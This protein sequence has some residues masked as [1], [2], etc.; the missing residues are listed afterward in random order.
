VVT[1]RSLTW[2]GA[3]LLLLALS[4]RVGADR[5]RLLNGAEVFDELSVSPAAFA[6]I[7]EHLPS[8][9]DYQNLVLYHP[10]FGYYTTGQVN[11]VDDFRTFPTLLAPYFGHMIAEQTFQMW[12]GMRRARTLREN[13]VFVIAEFGGGNGLLA[14]SILDYVNRQASVNPDVRWRDFHHQLRYLSVD[15]SDVLLA[16][17]RARNAR[18]GTQFEARAG[19]ATDMSRVFEPR[20]ITGVILSNELIDTFGVHKVIV[21]ATGDPEICYVAAALSQREWRRLERRLP[22]SLRRVVA[23]ETSIIEEALP[24]PRGQVWLTR[25]SLTALLETLA[26]S[27]TRQ[28]DV[29]MLDF[30]EIFVPVSFVPAVAEHMARYRPQYIS[31]LARTGQ[32][33]V[34]YVNLGIPAF[35]HNAA[36]AL[37]A[38]YVMTIDYGGGWREF[39]SHTARPHLRVYGPDTVPPVVA[40]PPPSAGD[41]PP[42]LLARVQNQRMSAD[43]YR[44]PT[45]N[46]ITTDVNFGVLS[47]EGRSAGLRAVYF[48]PQRALRFG[49]G[50]SLDTPPLM[51]TPAQRIDY[52]FWVR[53]FESN[54]TFKVLVQQKEGTDP[55]YN[56]LSPQN[57]SLTSTK[58]SNSLTRH[59]C[60]STIGAIHSVEDEWHSNQG[61]RAGSRVVN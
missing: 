11:F 49:T 34:T 27:P 40:V 52:G 53:D 43:P 37:N 22:D 26:T 44:A 15:R 35:V 61:I 32:S 51:R 28:S 33:Y 50:V 60:A 5:G 18:F 17:Q 57:T 30:H 55:T 14:E 36:D 12:A 46:D 59:R 13:A 20:S 8:F 58:L 24:R 41:P 48:G 7:A 9:F 25:A 19:D 16:Q 3:I 38:G 2:A 39:L 31:P 56:G 4:D 47:E 1:F 45:L 29:G 23:A 54:D 6:N 42:Q 10:S 21:N